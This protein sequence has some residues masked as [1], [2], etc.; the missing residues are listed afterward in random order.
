MSL[1][2]LLEIKISFMHYCF[3][4]NCLPYCNGIKRINRTVFN[5]HIKRMDYKCSCR[6]KTTTKKTQPRPSKNQNSNVPLQQSCTRGVCTSEGG[7]PFPLASPDEATC[8]CDVSSS[9]VPR[10]RGTRTY[11]R[12]SN[13]GPQRWLGTGASHIWEKTQ[14]A[15]TVHS[16]EGFGRN[17]SKFVNALS[18]GAKSTVPGSF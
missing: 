18:E 2:L 6:D 16:G 12:E 8:G 3:N 7:D 10:T 9:G 13:E 4:I 17:L 1:Q 11:C 15:A 14:R 5:C